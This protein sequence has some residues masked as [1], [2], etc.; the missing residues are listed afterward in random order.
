MD[1]F[2]SVCGRAVAQHESQVNAT[3]RRTKTVKATKQLFIVPLGRILH[4]MIRFVFLLGSAGLLRVRL[5]R[6]S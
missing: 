3:V 2:L 1:V 4:L 6:D 5:R